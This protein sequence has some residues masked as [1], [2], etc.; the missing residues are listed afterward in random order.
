MINNCFVNEES[1]L[2]VGCLWHVPKPILIY[3]VFLLCVSPRPVK[4]D[5]VYNFDIGEISVFRFGSGDDPLGIESLGGVGGIG[6][7]TTQSFSASITVACDA[8]DF[9][10]NINT[11]LNQTV[12]ASFR[13]AG[14]EALVTDSL[15]I[16]FSDNRFNGLDQIITSGTIQFNGGTANYTIAATLPGD[17]FSFSNSLDE[18]PRF[19]GAIVQPNSSVSNNPYLFTLSSENGNS[20][21]V[22][23]S[24][25]EPSATKLFLL[26][27]LGMV[28]HGRRR[29][30]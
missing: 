7:G 27:G 4:A 21:T 11:V 20:V 24:I 30:L 23:S 28:L 5:L 2:R 25:P 12:D 13:I 1:I 19:S 29:S 26:T 15:S 17:T 9:N 16:V 18:A 6:P 22:T 3:A 8:Q 14:A 10:S